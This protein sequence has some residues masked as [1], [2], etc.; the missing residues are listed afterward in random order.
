MCFVHAERE[1]GEPHST[2]QQVRGA[3]SGRILMPFSI[4]AL[5]DRMPPWPSKL[6]QVFHTSFFSGECPQEHNNKVKRL[7]LH[8]LV[9]R[10]WSTRTNILAIPFT[11]SLLRNLH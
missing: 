6:E 3:L 8:S 10:S 2:N 1:P 4:G 9:L 5:G 7:L 11:G